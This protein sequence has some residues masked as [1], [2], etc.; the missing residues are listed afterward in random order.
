M[1]DGQVKEDSIQ[2][3]ES[4]KVAGAK[5]ARQRNGIDQGIWPG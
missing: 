1:L 4:P 2:E 5:A 3:G